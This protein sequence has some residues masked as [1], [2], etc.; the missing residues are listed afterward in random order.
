MHVDLKT[1]DPAVGL[2]IRDW[3]VVI[4][5]GIVHEHVDRAISG[6]RR[7]QQ[8]LTTFLFR[9]VASDTRGFATGVFYDLD[10]ARERPF[11]HVIAFVQGPSGA[12]NTGAFGG[13]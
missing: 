5:G 12:D 11:Q 8:L 9:D 2:I 3:N 10:S 6:P 1:A 7:F 13:E 4:E